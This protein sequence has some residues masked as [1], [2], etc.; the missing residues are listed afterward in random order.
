[1]LHLDLDPGIANNICLEHPGLQPIS[2][3]RRMRHRSGAHQ[4]ENM[5]FSLINALRNPSSGGNV[6]S[7]A[8]LLKLDRNDMT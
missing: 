4:A 5:G 6:G 3:N 7:Y 8:M 2:S 1:M